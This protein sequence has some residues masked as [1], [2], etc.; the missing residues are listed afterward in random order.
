M[1]RFKQID[2]Y[3]AL[4][5][6]KLL[7]AGRGYLTHVRRQVYNF[8]F[9]DIDKK[10]EEERRLLAALNSNGANGEDDLGVGDE[11]EPEEL[12]SQDPKEWKA[13]ALYHT[14]FL[15][16]LSDDRTYEQKQ[17]HYAVLGLS[18]LRYKATPDQ[19]KFARTLPPFLSWP[20]LI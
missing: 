11:E 1:Y 10:E 18:H 12:L 2:K 8:S 9:D 13:R 19:I 15:V 5:E 16:G 20:P 3:T 7:P 6:R 17:D 14:V 4:V